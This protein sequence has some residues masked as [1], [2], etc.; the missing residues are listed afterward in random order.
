MA[1]S[2][3]SVGLLAT[4]LV[5]LLTSAQA[6]QD[7]SSVKPAA[8][9]VP[10]N[11]RAA[12]ADLFKSE[13]VQLT[14]EAVQSIKDNDALA[15]HAHLFAFDHGNERSSSNE[16]ECKLLPGDDK[17]PQQFIWEAFDLLLDGA[18]VPIIPIASPCYENSPYDNYDPQECAVVVKNFTTSELQYAFPLFSE[19]IRCRPVPLTLTIARITPD[20]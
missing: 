4:T 20:L 10:S 2:R 5:S 18:L 8:A 12:G 11:S 6:N 1:S 13:T 15:Q 9:V 7:L 14:E 19:I 16:E 17:W 3:L